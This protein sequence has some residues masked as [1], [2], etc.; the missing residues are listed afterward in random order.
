LA[1]RVATVVIPEREYSAYFR[2]TAVVNRTVTVRDRG[3]AVNPG[4]PAAFVA[5]S[6]GRPLRSYDVR[7]RVLA[8]TGRIPNAVEVRAEQFRQRD[9]VRSLRTEVRQTQQQIRP[10]NQVAAPQPLRRGEPGRLGANPPRAAQGLQGQQPT[11]QGRGQPPQT[12]S[13][14]GQP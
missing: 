8:G 13:K 3:F 7:P 12:Q 2:E 6:I 11:T 9:A 14:Q 4:I 5:A 1:P 10:S